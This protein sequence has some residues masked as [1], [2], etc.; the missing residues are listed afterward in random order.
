VDELQNIAECFNQ[1]SS[2]LDAVACG[3]CLSM[4]DPNPP[5]SCDEAKAQ[6][7][8]KLDVCDSV[9]GQT[10]CRIELLD[11]ATTCQGMFLDCDIVDCITAQ[12]SPSATTAPTQKVSTTSVPPTPATSSVASS[13]SILVTGTVVLATVGLWLFQVG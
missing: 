13:S 8:G 9:C 5:S 12:P 11:A 6:A 3:T 7:C 10:D 4:G 1:S 2:N